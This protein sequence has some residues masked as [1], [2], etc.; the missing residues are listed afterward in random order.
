MLLLS[1]SPPFR[2]MRSCRITGI[3]KGSTI[4]SMRMR[5]KTMMNG[6]YEGRFWAEHHKEAS[7][8]IG[9]LLGAIMQAFCV[10]NTIEYAAPWQS[11][12][13]TRPIK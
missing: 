6:G 8:A 9:R 12:R 10:L 3:H 13:A 4:K 1:V 11:S 5:R 2:H 7:A